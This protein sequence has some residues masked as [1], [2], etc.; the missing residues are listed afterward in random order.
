MKRIVEHLQRE[1]LLSASQVAAAVA[2]HQRTG[3]RVEEVIVEL[4]MLDESVLLRSLATLYRTRFATTERLAS[5]RVDSKLAE[6]VPRK[7]AEQ[8]LVCPMTFD[9]ESSVLT[10]VA[11][12]ADDVAMIHG[13]RVAA[14]AREVRAIVVRPAAAKA[15][16]A[17]VYGGDA[18]AFALLSREG[19]SRSGDVYSE[20]F[21][22]D[23]AHPTG[24]PGDRPTS[25]PPPT[26]QLQSPRTRMSDRPPPPGFGS[27]PSIGSGP[28]VTGPGAGFGRGLEAFRDVVTRL[29]GFYD[30]HDP[31]ANPGHPIHAAR[32]AKVLAERCTTPLATTQA[33]ELAALMHDLGKGGVG[34]LSTFNVAQ[35]AEHTAAAKR[36][37]TNPLRVF[38]GSKLPADV[39]AAIQHMYE[40][41]DG[42]G[43]PLGQRGREI[44]LGARLLAVADAYADLSEN[45]Q[46]AYRRRLGPEEAAAVVATLAESAFD[47]AIVE[48]LVQ[49]VGV[50]SSRVVLSPA[51]REVL[52]LDP[53]L[54][55]AALLCAPGLEAGFRVR[56]AHAPEAARVALA[57]ARF[58]LLLVDADDVPW[59]FLEELVAGVYGVSIPIAASGRN[60]ER[61]TVER[62]GLLHAVD[63]AP[64]SLS[65]AVLFDRLRVALDAR[66]A[67]AETGQR[68]RLQDTELPDVIQ[69][70]VQGRKTGRLLVRTT[71]GSGEIHFS[72]GAIVDGYFGERV[73]DEAVIAMVRVRE[74]EFVFEPSFNPG[75]PRIRTTTEMLLLE[76][77]RRLDESSLR[78]R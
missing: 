20:A 53:S 64:K 40:R 73:A 70:L 1:G 26:E 57:E 66:R 36:V 16:I 58:D 45:P 34:H 77:M 67:R 56:I 15:L 37:Y 7:Y 32:V 74:G 14:S 30:A 47:P 52:V 25:I 11:P 49:V 60:L 65:P 48:A 3:S 9:P 61:A 2:H 62:F 35:Y 63:V 23:S 27:S 39:G 43:F 33:L 17:R 12:D 38:E 41:F 5:F 54:D 76:A 28:T 21:R 51:W 19:A 50:P 22:G 13:L 78:P 46:N 71:R 44:P 72:S 42:R 24:R 55:D 59:R 8:S 75:A 6:L 31:H 69:T 29:M 68:G 18:H 10:V 4:A